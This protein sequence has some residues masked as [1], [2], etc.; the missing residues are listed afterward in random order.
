MFTIKVRECRQHRQPDVLAKKLNNRSG[1]DVNSA[2]RGRQLEPDALT[3][4]LTTL[5]FSK[6]ILKW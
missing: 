2:R 3:R 1:P 5:S 6:Q 4:L